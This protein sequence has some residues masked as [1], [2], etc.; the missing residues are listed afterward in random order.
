[1][2]IPTAVPR[3]PQLPLFHGQ[4]DTSVP[5]PRRGDIVMAR[6][7]VMK[8]H[9]GVMPAIP[10]TVVTQSSGGTSSASFLYE[11]EDRRFAWHPCVVFDHRWDQQDNT[12]EMEVCVC[13]T[14]S[15]LPDPASI[16]KD[17]PRHYIPVPHTGADGSTTKHPF[18]P[19]LDT[20]G[21]LA[22]KPTWLVALKYSLPMGSHGA[23]CTR[24]LRLSWQLRCALWSDTSLCD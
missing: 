1:M 11:A 24:Y 12:W 20:N 15:E 16:A 2:S 7:N 18:E 23:V 8:L 10:A 19:P 14:Y 9:T 4:R 22:V 5:F 6:V 3:G 13:R 17:H 21:Y